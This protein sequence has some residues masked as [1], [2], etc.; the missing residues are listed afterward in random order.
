MGKFYD[1]ISQDHA[2]WINKQKLF[3][4]ATAPL[5]PQGTVNASPKGYDSFRI[6]GPNRVCYLDLT[7][8]GIETQSHLQE[9]SRISFLFMAFE[10]GPRILRLF[11]RGHVARVDT[12]EFETLFDKHFRRQHTGSTLPESSDLSDNSDDLAL[13]SEPYELEGASQIRAIIVADIHKI[14]TSCGWGIPFY[15]YKGERPTLKSFW[16]K[17]P[18]EKL[19]K[20][21]VHANTQS[22]DGLPGMRHELM[23][24]EW[25]P[26]SSDQNKLSIFGAINAVIAGSTGGDHFATSCALVILGF[27]TGIASSLFLLKKGSL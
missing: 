27:G 7:G 2:E 16:G 18:K 15:E 17:M 6:I 21:W 14:G 12:P 8:S 5:D 26:A 23:G 19:A 11:G 24:S 3:F 9:N 1:E 4:V 13:A 20:F 10:G 22:I 25:A